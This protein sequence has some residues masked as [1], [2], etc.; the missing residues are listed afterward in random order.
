MVLLNWLYHFDLDPSTPNPELPK[1]HA[2]GVALLWAIVVVPVIGVCLRAGRL[3][4]VWVA[5]LVGGLLANGAVLLLRDV[6]R[7]RHPV[8][9]PVVTQ[10]QERSGGGTRCPG[11]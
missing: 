7:E 4:I 3:R 2:V 11:G 1:A 8:P 5:L 10:C 6:E 9:V